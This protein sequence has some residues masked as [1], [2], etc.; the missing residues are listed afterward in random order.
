MN[1]V[2][3]A[4]CGNEIKATGLVVSRTKVWTPNVGEFKGKQICEECHTQIQVAQ[5]AHFD[6]FSVGGFELMYPTSWG[7]QSKDM[8]TQKSGSLV[9]VP[10]GRKGNIYLFWGPLNDVKR[11]RSAREHAEAAAKLAKRETGWQGGR[12]KHVEIR[13]GEVNG[14]ESCTC[15]LST[16]KMKPGPFPPLMRGGGHEAVQATYFHCQ[17]SSRYFV[18]V[19]DVGYQGNSVGNAEHE[20]LVR[21]FL[22]TFNCHL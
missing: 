19:A 12:T 14:H 20:N 11:Y 9:F 17:V 18:L 3:C 22:R 10:P 21:N 4:R 2:Y 8:M 15:D 7:V 13:T 16:F 6:K 5:D 1:M